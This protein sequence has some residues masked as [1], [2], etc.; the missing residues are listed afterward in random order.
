M[1]TDSLVTVFKARK[2]S[3]SLNLF[4]EMRTFA[5]DHDI[6]ARTIVRM[7]TL[8]GA[9]ALGLAGQ[10]G[11]IAEGALADLIAIPFAGKVAEVWEALIHHP[12]E[13]TAS[14]IDG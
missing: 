14:L 1:G 10:A 4:E 8:N 11:E 5:A 13:V 7:A 9:R 2:E 3:V 6:P 12:G